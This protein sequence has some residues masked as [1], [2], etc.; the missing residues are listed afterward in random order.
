MS[1]IEKVE[2]EAY[3]K[4]SDIIVKLLGNCSDATLVQLTLLAERLNSAP[5]V[6]GAIRSIREMLH[7]PDYAANKLFKRVLN[8]LP[9]ET[10]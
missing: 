10:R 6:L 7:N 4:I 9:Y 1:V 5:E 3:K 8:Y 2:S